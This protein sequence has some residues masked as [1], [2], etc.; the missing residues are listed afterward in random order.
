VFALVILADILT[1]Y[2]CCLLGF[3]A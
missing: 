1:Y 2:V 3:S